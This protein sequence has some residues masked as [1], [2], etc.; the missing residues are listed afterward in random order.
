MRVLSLFKRELFGLKIK[1]LAKTFTKC[2]AGLDEDYRHVL[3]SQTAWVRIL[4]LP[5]LINP[6]CPSVSSSNTGFTALFSG[7]KELIYVQGLEQWLVRSST[8]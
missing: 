8:I 4:V 1:R 7:S 5:K 6:M 3:G 2:T